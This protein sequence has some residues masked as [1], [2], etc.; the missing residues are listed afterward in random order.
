[1]AADPEF[2]GE[3]FLPGLPGEIA[4]EHWH[5][6]AFARGLVA[7]RRVLDAACGE[8]YGTAL[9][10][11]VAVEAIGV[12]ID[13]PTIERARANYAARRHIRFETGSVTALPLADGAAEVVVSFETIEHLS[14]AD[15][16]RMLA[17]FARVLSPGGFLVLSSPNK[18]RYSDERSYA[19]PFHLHELYRDDLARLLDA[20]F[21]ARLWIHQAPMLASALWNE[22]SASGA[23]AWMGDGREVLPMRAP[24]GLYYLVVAAKADSALPHV[25]PKLSVFVDAG[26][27]ELKRAEANAAEVLRLDGLLLQRDRTIVE[28]DA[29]LATARIELAASEAARNA[30]AAARAESERQARDSIGA[31]DA[32]RRRLEGAITAQERIIAYRQSARWWIQLPWLRIRLAWQRW[33]GR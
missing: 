18:R 7:G 12:D 8:G 32:E 19:N 14:A 3:R 28:R 30:Q 33:F 5:R 6:Y 1:M 4:Y 15:Q 26:D 24:D 11:D 20:G 16:P 29:A 2:T 23:E 21:P 17:E 9:L 27:S 25:I 22:S 13:A 31:L 10:A